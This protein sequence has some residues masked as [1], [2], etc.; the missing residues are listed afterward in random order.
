MR[1][2]QGRVIVAIVCCAGGLLWPST[3]PA[4]ILITGLDMPVVID[5]NEFTGA[6]FSPGA[7]PASGQLDSNIWS[8]RG[9]SEG[10]VAFGG[11][12]T[13]GDFARGTHAGGTS[14]GGIYA[15][16]V[17][18]SAAVNRALGIQPTAADFNP[19]ELV[20]RLVNQ[21]S[22]PVSMWQI[23]YDVYVY[24]DQGRSS[25]FNFSYSLDDST[26]VTVP[27]LDLTSP[28]SADGV[29]AWVQNTRSITVATA[30]L[31]G[32]NENLFLR[33]ST[34]DVSG[35]GSRDELALDNISI[36]AHTNVVP[37]PA[38]W[39]IWMIGLVAGLIGRRRIKSPCRWSRHWFR[40]KLNHG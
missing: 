18:G 26:Y 10:N 32:I 34:H 7:A 19:G 6:G 4:G 14:T 40:P 30:S 1:C 12:N 38:S 3:A 13:T 17:D 8:V 22:A 33:W 28:E 27:G 5:F 16:D 20:L 37:E 15:F 11:T 23:A 21:T 2:V 36:S 31:V 24:N 29:A 9:L 25:A 35:L 39:M